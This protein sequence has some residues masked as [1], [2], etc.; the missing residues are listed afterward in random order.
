MAACKSEFTQQ[1]LQLGKIIK[2]N[3]KRANVV[4]II[5]LPKSVQ[6]EFNLQYI[7]LINR[8][9]EALELTLPRHTAYACANGFHATRIM[10]VFYTNCTCKDCDCDIDYSFL[11]YTG[12]SRRNKTPTWRQLETLLFVVDMHKNIVDASNLFAV[13]VMQK[14]K[15]EKRK[16][17]R[18]FIFGGE[19]LNRQKLQ[20]TILKQYKVHQQMLKA[21]YGACTKARVMW[22][23]V[24]RAVRMYHYAH[25][26]W[27]YK[28]GHDIVQLDIRASVPFVCSHPLQ[29]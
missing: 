3:R 29:V 12:S 22:A 17:A 23:R 16:F 19:S 13:N 10:H 14:C 26:L 11:R 25:K 4:S 5:N 15:N 7:E 21:V 9:E 28:F 1:A 24:R 6:N 20:S 18:E 8:M 27:E 2:R